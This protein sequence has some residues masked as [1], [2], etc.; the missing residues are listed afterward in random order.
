MRE[1]NPK[2]GTIACEPFARNSLEVRR[3]NGVAI[4]TQRDQLTGLKVVYG[5]AD[6]APGDIVFFEGDQCAQLWAKKVYTIDGQKFVLAPVNLVMVV[7]R[8]GF[9][10]TS[11]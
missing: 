11:T 7:E 6:F 3:E 9:K 10:G 1:A 4:P 5:T 2:S 8:Q